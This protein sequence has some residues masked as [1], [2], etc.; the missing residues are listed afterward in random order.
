MKQSR[1]IV[2]YREMER[3]A[4]NPNITDKGQWQLYK[5]RK[6]LRPHVDFQKEREAA[7]QKK[8]SHYADENGN[9]NGPIV[10]EYMDDMN[11]LNEMEVELEEF[12]KPVIPISGVNFLTMENLEDF[13]EFTE[14]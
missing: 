13:I 1:I 4:N 7:I 8:Y 2:A 11:A 14:T 10:K 5:L 6:A 12:E 9:I 3:L